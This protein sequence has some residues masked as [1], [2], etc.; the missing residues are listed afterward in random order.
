MSLS[1]IK[2]IT[3][4]LMTL[5]LVVLALGFI[6]II[7]IGTMYISVGVPLSFVNIFFVHSAA[8]QDAA[9]KQWAKRIYA[10]YI[11]LFVLFTLTFILIGIIFSFGF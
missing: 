4:A 10:F 5:T 9:Y 11:T 3:Y 8:N 7:G 6:P 1:K 2:K